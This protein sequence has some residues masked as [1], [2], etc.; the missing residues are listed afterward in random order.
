MNAQSLIENTWFIAFTSSVIT[1]LVIL[2]GLRGIWK[3][4]RSLFGIFSG[5][6]IA[7]TWAWP[8][9]KIL[10]E[11][12]SCRHIG[13]TLI[14]RIRGVAILKKEPKSK[15]VQEV[16]TNKGVYK[17]IGS[18]NERLF[19]ISYKTTIPALRSS[20]AIALQGDSKGKVFSGGWVGLV[21]ERVE[22]AQCTWLM[23]DKKISWKRNREQLIEYAKDIIS[24]METSYDSSKIIKILSMIG[25]IGKGRI[26]IHGESGTGKSIVAHSIH[27]LLDKREQ[28]NSDPLEGQVEE[29]LYH[30]KSNTQQSNETNK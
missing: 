5:Q 11:E 12:V 30:K 25:D 21:E 3:R 14:G 15:E 22:H 19:V 6:Y 29:E 13:D 23:I 26:R 18:V 17:F 20:G 27:K 1:A 8:E 16:A 10:L 7:F 4:L 28:N 2:P 24:S 9:Q